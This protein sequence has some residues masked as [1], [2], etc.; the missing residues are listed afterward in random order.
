[1]A[2]TYLVTGENIA[3]ARV[4]MTVFSLAAG[5]ALFDL[6]RRTTSHW[7]ALVALAFYLVLPFSVQAS[8]SFQP[9][10]LMTS[11][12]VIGVYFLYRWSEEQTWK[13]A[14]FAGVFLGLATFVK[15]VI[16]FFVGAAAIALV[17]FTLGRNFWRSK[18]VWAMAAVMVVQ[19][20]LFMFS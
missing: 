3:V 2:Y 19:R 12:F 16:A 9:D 17:L 18:Q 8:R 7:A 20:Y 1:M 13:W 10:P 11:A 15:I 5:V 6:M 14:I 4:W